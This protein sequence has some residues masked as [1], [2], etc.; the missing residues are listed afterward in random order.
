MTLARAG[1]HHVIVLSSDA[2]IPPPTAG[3]LERDLLEA[4][5]AGVVI[6]RRPIPVGP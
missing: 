4:R 1:L 3:G 6:E 5:G 2:A